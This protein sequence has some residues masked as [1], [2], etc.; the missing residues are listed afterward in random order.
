MFRNVGEESER[1]V[2]AAGDVD[3]RCANDAA[4]IKAF[5]DWHCH[6]CARVPDL[7]ALPAV[8]ATGTEGPLAR[9][10]FKPRLREKAFGI[11]SDWHVEAM[12]VVVQRIVLAVEVARVIGFWF[13]PTN[14]CSKHN[15]LDAAGPQ[16]NRRN[17]AG[18]HDGIAQCHNCDVGIIIL[19]QRIPIGMQKYFFDLETC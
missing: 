8:E 18:E 1:D 5:V 16:A 19:A 4:Q 10:R 15:L 13:R 12:R 14:D 7:E 3:E 11:G 6:G 2:I 17:H 9:D